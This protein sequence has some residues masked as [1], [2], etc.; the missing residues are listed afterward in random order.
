MASQPI[1]I[2]RMTAELTLC[3][4]VQAVEGFSRE[5]YLA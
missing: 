5:E 3:V 4:S 1:K 2:R